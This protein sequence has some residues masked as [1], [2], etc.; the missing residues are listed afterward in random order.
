MSRSCWLAAR[1]A[2]SRSRPA[3]KV[4]RVRSTIWWSVQTRLYVISYLP[5]TE[6]LGTSALSFKQV[7]LPSSEFSFFSANNCLHF[8]YHT[9]IGLRC[10][11]DSNSVERAPCR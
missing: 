4:I 11:M 9:S 2:Q 3:R 10:F 8:C 6:L 7:S 5:V 1:K